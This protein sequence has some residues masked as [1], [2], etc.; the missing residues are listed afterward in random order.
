MDKTTHTVRL[1]QWT[2]I[3]QA[4]LSSGM[5]K[6]DWCR[7]NGIPEKRFYYWQRRVRND[8]Y[9]VGA[10][11]LVPSEGSNHPDLGELPVAR[12]YRNIAS[13]NF[14]PAAVITVGNISVGITVNI[15]ESLLMSIG[16]MIHH[17]L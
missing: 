6:R 17:A 11:A 2:E 1:Q 16:K 7:K 14:S 10:G 13:E 9:E 5:N 15:S 4:Q 3:I 12:S 8:L